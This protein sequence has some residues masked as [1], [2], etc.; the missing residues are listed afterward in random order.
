M[1][2]PCENF[3]AINIL[4]HIIIIIAD[5]AYFLFLTLI[6]RSI[7]NNNDDKDIS[8]NNQNKAKQSNTL[9][10]ISSIF[11]FIS[12]IIIMTEWPGRWGI[13]WIGSMIDDICI[14]FLVMT[15][16][17]IIK[18]NQIVDDTENNALLDDQTDL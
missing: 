8:I 6:Y 15:S 16:H 17:K 10:L 13:I 7:Y 2:N 11:T 4:S 3:T 9:M 5:L 18:N 12:V 1:V 14:L